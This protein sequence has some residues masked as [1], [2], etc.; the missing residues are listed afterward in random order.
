MML[1][2]KEIN[3]EAINTEHNALSDERA[4]I[5]LNEYREILKAGERECPAMS[6]APGKKRKPKQGKSRNLLVRL[7]DFETEVLRFMTNPLVP[8]TNNDG[9]G[10]LRMSKVQQKI[11]GCF[12]SMNAAKNWCLVRS[13]I[14]TCGKHGMP[15]MEALEMLFNNKLPGFMQDLLKAEIQS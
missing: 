5:R 2:L 14:V 6:P 4:I 9:E 1:L 12:K 10:D 8:F 11:S 7:R 3:I 13:Y 15:A